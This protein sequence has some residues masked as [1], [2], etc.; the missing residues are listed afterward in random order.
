MAV[1]KAIVS[2]LLIALINDWRCVH[3]SRLGAIQRV[4][5]ESGAFS[6][7]VVRQSL[8][9]QGLQP[10]YHNLQ[11]GLLYVKALVRKG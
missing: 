8:A 9:P 5:F 10:I 4:S 3:Q 1:F 2:E 6:R 11:R 7:S